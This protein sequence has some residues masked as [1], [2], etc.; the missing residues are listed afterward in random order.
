MTT[1]VASYEMNPTED[2]VIFGDQLA[3][4]MWVIPEASYMR[5]RGS[6]EDARLRG[7]RFRQVTQLRHLPGQGNIP[8]Q[9]AFI[10]VWVDGYQ[11]IHS[12]AVTWGWIVKKDSLS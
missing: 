7:E 3:E 4:G 6:G 5:S 2:V 9:T 11:E 1:T 10:G 12:M 8:E